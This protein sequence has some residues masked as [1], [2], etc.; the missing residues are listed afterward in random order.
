MFIS[1]SFEGVDGYDDARK[2]A[3][4]D[5]RN[6]FAYN[7]KGVQQIPSMVDANGGDGTDDTV[8]IS[9]TDEEDNA[10]GDGGNHG[11][12]N[13]GNHGGN[14]GNFDG[15]MFTAG[16]WPANLTI[17][18]TLQNPP[19]G[20]PP[21]KRQA[22]PPASPS[23]QNQSGGNQA[24]GH[25]AGGNQAGGH[26]AGGNQSNGPQYPYVPPPNQG[27]NQSTQNRQSQ[28]TQGTQNHQ[29]QGT[30]GTQ[31]RQSQ[32][33]QPRRYV[34]SQSFLHSSQPQVVY[35]LFYYTYRKYV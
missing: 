28:G 15:G 19:P 31:N 3:R 14:N 29:S 6:E 20:P 21:Q 8:D 4:E 5:I 1:G 9:N 16:G 13:G 35:C 2:K 33:G 12:D 26:Q 10:N 32:G 7:M 23:Q 30:Q 11:G 34:T 18:L 22:A 17:P 25:Q 24:G 27:G